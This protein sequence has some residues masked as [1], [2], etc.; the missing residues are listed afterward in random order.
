M[1][2]SPEAFEMIQKGGMLLLL[3]IAVIAL[4]LDRNRLLTSL[5]KKDT[6]IA[7]KDDQL[8]EVTKNTITTMAELKGLLSGRR[9]VA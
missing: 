3:V 6:V 1:L 5:S 8:L 2:I 4:A 7:K 9:D